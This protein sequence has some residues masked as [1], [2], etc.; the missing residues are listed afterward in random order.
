MIKK[1]SRCRFSETRLNLFWPNFAQKPRASWH[2]K[3][4]NPL[5]IFAVQVFKGEEAKDA[6]NY[7]ALLA[8]V[9]KD[10]YDATKETFDSSHDLFQ[11]TFKDGFSWEVLQVFTG[12]PK[13]TFSWRHWGVFN[14][15]YRERIGDNEKYEMFGFCEVIVTEQL[16]IQSI[17]VYYKPEEFLKTL[18]GQVSLDNLKIGKSIMGD[19][20]P[21]VHKQDV[22]KKIDETSNPVN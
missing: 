13:V 6:G 20:C 12:P 22:K 15:V 16:K 3:N 9:G 7:N 11:N 18:E 21:I 14:G 19:G 8:G 5:I 2:C 17:E 4:H 1:F 10:I